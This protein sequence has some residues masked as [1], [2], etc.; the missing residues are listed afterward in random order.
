MLGHGL[1]PA[2]AARF[3]NCKKLDK[4]AVDAHH[5][6]DRRRRARAVR[7]ALLVRSTMMMLLLLLLMMMMTMMMMM[8]KEKRYDT[9]AATAVAADMIDRREL[10]LPYAAQA[11]MLGGPGGSGLAYHTGDH[12]GAGGDMLA[13]QQAG[14][15]QQRGGQQQADRILPHNHLL[16]HGK[17]PRDNT[18]E[19]GE[20]ALTPLEPKTLRLVGKVKVKRLR[21]FGVTTVEDLAYLKENGFSENHDRLLAM[22][23]TK[24]KRPDLAVKTLERW[25]N[26]AMQHLRHQH[27]IISHEEHRNNNEV[28][29]VTPM[30]GHLDESRSAAAA[31][32]SNGAMAVHCN[33]HNN[34]NNNMNQPQD[35]GILGF[36]AML[37]ELALAMTNYDPL[38]T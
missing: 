13:Q 33:N 12:P 35:G 3:W 5:D 21:Q 6:D 25:C 38:S 14:L 37:E 27:D 19:L 9:F 7:R 4:E 31:A 16:T 34:I 28:V 30:F 8:I 11:I 32:A 23:I 1:V 20:Q 22:S 2:T 17:R 10:D 18:V 26:S 29:S 36:G 24:N 15:Q